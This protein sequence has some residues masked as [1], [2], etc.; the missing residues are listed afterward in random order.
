MPLHI[1]DEHVGTAYA[2]TQTGLLF[3]LPKPADGVEQLPAGISLCMIVKN[4]ERFLPECLRS[5]EGIVDE[6]CIVDTGSTDRTVEIAH[7]FGAKVEHREWRNDFSWAKN[8]ALAMATR[9]WTLVL[10]ADEEIVAETRPLLRA[11]RET[12]AD[13]SAVYVRIV[14]VVDDMTGSGVM[15]HFLPRLFPTSPR[16]RYR[17]PIHENICLDGDESELPGVLAPIRILHKGYT[18]AVL[19]GRKKF[20]R[21][22][23]LLE[24]ALER[25]GDDP[26]ALYNFGVALISSGDAARG[27]EFLER[28]FAL[29]HPP[30]VFY[31]L[32]Y[33]V[34]SVAY[35]EQ[36]DDPERGKEVLDKGLEIFPDHVN[37]VFTKAFF[38]SREARYD[39]A[40][41]LYERAMTLRHASGHHAMVDDEIFEWK[42]AYNLASTYL[43]EERVEEAV[44][45]LEAALRNKPS[46]SFLSVAA[47]N[48]YERLGR[49]YDVERIYRALYDLNP[50]EGILS[51][52]TFLLRRRRFAQAIEL[53]EREQH[54]F[55]NATI[56]AVNTS[57]A[58][59]AEREGFGDPEQFALR[60][61][62]AVPDDGGAL[63]F[64]ERYYERR[65]MTAKLERLRERDLEIVCTKPVHFSRRAYRLLSLGRCEEALDAARA[66]LEI[67]PGD[68][69]LRYDGALA[70]ARLQRDEEAREQLQEIHGGDRIALS[71]KLLLAQIEA[72]AGH[73]DAARAA[74]DAA[75]ALAPADVEA[76][77]GRAALH[78]REG[79]TGDAEHDYRAALRGGDRR[80]AVSLASLLMREGRLAEAGAIATEALAG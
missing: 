23:P 10:D 63:G 30:R 64:L 3:N 35:Y 1:A 20:E 71:A 28:M 15:T 70:L 51:Y 54:R 67:A 39:D 19:E 45:Y 31:A 46:S 56:A 9:R 40:R 79:R 68:T 24:K 34:L 48:A 33:V 42:A 29:G 73:V 61:L 75:L 4:E 69:A 50:D 37:L 44:P 21:N 59:I 17:N 60:A 47:A 58:G 78:D 6:I 22:R 55:S 32:A 52:V 38:A 49:W 12:P 18:S 66:G 16:I 77:L 36:L 26:F 74:Y 72:R 53:V 80:A 41:E 11:L 57:M 65:G 5:V 76:L 2:K 43:K 62:A 25:D 27:A 14:N 8:E 13:V 7:E